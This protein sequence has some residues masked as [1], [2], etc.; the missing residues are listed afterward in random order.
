MK[1]LFLLTALVFTFIVTSNNS[2][3]GQMA[4]LPF[5]ASKSVPPNIMLMIDSSGSM[6]WSMTADGKTARR[7]DFVKE[8]LAGSGNNT[9]TFGGDTVYIPHYDINT[10]GDH[11]VF[12]EFV[13]ESLVQI[14]RVE[15]NGYD[16]NYGM[17]SYGCADG[18]E[19]FFFFSPDDVSRNDG[20]VLDAL[21]TLDGLPART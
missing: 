6:G 11:S 12:A 16:Y 5:T 4:E 18:G 7:M 1:K 8:V 21:D 14:V 17:P 3:F 15:Y 20:D 2:A 13:K 10:E 19:G 9:L